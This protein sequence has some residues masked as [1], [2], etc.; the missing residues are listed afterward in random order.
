MN[1]NKVTVLG[2][3]NILMGDEGFGVHFVRWFSKRYRTPDDVRIVDGGTLGYVLLDIICR[4]DHLIVV[5]VLK[6]DDAPGSIY[7]FTKEEMEMHMPPPT[8]AHEVTFPDVLFKSEML[9][10]APATIFLC[11]IPEN[12]KDLDMNMSGFLFDKFNDMEKLL[13]SELEKLNILPERLPDA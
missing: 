10:E 8:T 1:I 9:G 5:D 13:V 2:I 4:C 7:R 12:F 11:I 6:L 3:G